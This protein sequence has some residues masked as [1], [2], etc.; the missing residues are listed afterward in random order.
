MKPRSQLLA[1]EFDFEHRIGFRLIVAAG[2]LTEGAKT[3]L[4][5]EHRMS[6]ANWRVMVVVGAYGPLPAKDV[7]E[8]TAQPPDRITRTIDF[9]ETQGWVERRRDDSDRRRVLLTMTP[10]GRRIYD[11]IEAIVR[12][13]NFQMMKSM[14]R[15]ERATFDRLLR[16]YEARGREL[17][18]A[19]GGWRRIAK[20]VKRGRRSA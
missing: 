10:A 12:E 3:F 13:A 9:F 16:K 14:T 6:F 8:R 7:A 18:E 20:M 5:A 19:P 17:L 1:P 4:R 2:W 11:H 15:P